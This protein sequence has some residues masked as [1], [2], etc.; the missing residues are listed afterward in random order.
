MYRVTKTQEKSKAVYEISVA[1]CI[2]NQEITAQ[3]KNNFV[4]SNIFH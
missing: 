1:L 2:Y 4:V 3:I